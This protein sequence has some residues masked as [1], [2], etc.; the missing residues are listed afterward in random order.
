MPFITDFYGDL[1]MNFS[2]KTRIMLGSLTGVLSGLIFFVVAYFSFDTI[3]SA[4][5]WVDHTHRVIKQALLIEA[6]AVNMETGMRGFLLAGKDEFLE[7]YNSGQSGIYKKIDSLMKTVSDNPRQVELLKEIKAIMSAWQ[8]NITEP[9]IAKRRRVAKGGSMNTIVVMVGKAEG[10][11][12]FDQFRKMIGTFI[13]REQV[14]IEQ[15]ITTAQNASQYALILLSL[16]VLIASLVSVFFFNRLANSIVKPIDNI[17]LQLSRSS[18]ELSKNSDSSVQRNNQINSDTI[19]QSQLMEST[20]SALE[21]IESTVKSNEENA[22]TSS[23]LAKKVKTYASEANGYMAN[24]LKSMEKVE[25]SSTNIE[26]L[27]ETIKSIEEQTIIINDIAFQTSLLSF[28]ASIESARAGEHGKDSQ[29][30]LKRL[31]N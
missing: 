28:N 24:L 2:L 27:V 11:K 17:N 14:L 23:E 1:S 10:K 25:A 8:K 9:A 16:A 15:R 4:N 21:E 29:L 30:L 3:L 5:K 7:P 26:G 22:F 18:T 12:Y 19:T 20:S 13:Q 31:G 6:D